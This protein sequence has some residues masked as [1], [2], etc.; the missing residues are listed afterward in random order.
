MNREKNRNYSEENLKA[1][2][3]LYST[4][5][6]ETAAQQLNLVTSPELYSNG[7][8]V[9]WKCQ[10]ARCHRR[11]HCPCVSGKIDKAN[12]TRLLTPWY[13]YELP[14]QRIEICY[15]VAKGNEEGWMTWITILLQ[16]DSEKE[17]VNIVQTRKNRKWRMIF[18]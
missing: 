9:W 3:Y 15:K 2:L 6:A 5:V 4:E 1:S 12:G 11:E 10:G 18:K 14:I 7:C 8:T 16:K 17:N 13:L